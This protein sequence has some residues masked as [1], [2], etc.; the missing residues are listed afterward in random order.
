MHRKGRATRHGSRRGRHECAL[1]G[2]GYS[3][4]RRGQKARSRGGWMIFG[5]RS[6]F[7]IFTANSYPWLCFV[8]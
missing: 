8:T 3:G 1:A 4:P 5:C 6:L 7:D 2:V